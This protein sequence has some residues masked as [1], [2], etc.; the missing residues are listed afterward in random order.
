MN[1]DELG[2]IAIA[3]ADAARPVPLRYFR[4]PLAVEAKGDLSPV[5]IADR[6]TELAMRAVLDARCPDHGVYGEEHGQQGLDRRFVWVIDPI[7]GTKSFI[8]GMP[9]FTTLIAL[10]D[11]GRPVLGVID[12]PAMGERYHAVR[13]KGAFRDGTPISVSGCRRLAE[14]VVY[15]AGHEP[16][17]GELAGRMARLRGRGRLER[18]AYDGFAYAQLASGHVDIMIETDLEPYD[19][20]ALVNVV[21]EAGGTITDWSGEP[22]SLNS[23]GDVLATAS[24]E[25]HDEVLGLL[26]D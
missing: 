26:G 17:D 14:A 1:I 10:L 24:R 8:S 2:G 23:K 11:E 21:E 3:V 6:E 18:Y 5:T 4:K 12:V 7:D 25:L 15:I 19:Y 20:M 16:D 22:L 9:L 13:G